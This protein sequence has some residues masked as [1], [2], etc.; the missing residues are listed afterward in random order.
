VPQGSILGPLLILVY[1]NDIISD[2]NANI[3]LF[4]DDTNLFIV[5]EDPI[6]ASTILNTD[7]QKIISWAEKWLVKFNPLKTESL[8]L[9]LKTNRL[10][11][12]PPIIMQNTQIKELHNHKH[13][14][15]TFI[16]DLRWSTHIEYIKNKAW[17][18][19]NV[20]KKKLTRQELTTNHVPIFYKTDY[21]IWR[22]TI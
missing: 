21:R 22:C 19:I 3:R 18:R 16:H 17:K 4:T 9:S 20:M 13:L 1:I 7:L 5:V 15:I 14:G 12:H 6:T 10:I 2:I 8:L 11:N